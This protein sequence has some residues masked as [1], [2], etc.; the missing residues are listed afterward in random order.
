MAR[1]GE[2]EIA[3]WHQM[4]EEGKGR[5]TLQDG[6]CFWSIS[7]VSIYKLALLRVSGSAGSKDVGGRGVDEAWDQNR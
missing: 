5:A 1:E 7:K 4:E 6:G 2:I 3:H